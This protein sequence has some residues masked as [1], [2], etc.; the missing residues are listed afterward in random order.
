MEI[1]AT[2]ESLDAAITTLRGELADAFSRISSQADAETFRIAYLSRNGKVAA[3]FESMKTLP[4]TDKPVF[5]KKL[6]EL[7]KFAEGTF[8]ETAARIETAAASTRST[9]DLTLPGR[10]LPQGTVHPITQTLNEIKSIFFAMGFDLADGPEIEDDYHNFE[11]LNFH[12]NHP[13]RDMQDTFFVAKDVLLRTHTSP[14]QIRVMK[15]Q[16]PPIRTIMPGR[17][18]RNE[19]IS[20]RSY[21]MFHQ[22]EG[23]FVDK[24]VTFSELKGTLVAF[25]KQF[26]GS[27]IKYKFRPSYFPFTEPSLEM[28]I[29]CF[30]C[31]GKGC[32]IC[33]HS[34]WLEVLG[35]GM[36]H[37]NVFK[38]VG[39]DSDAYTGYAF[40]MGIERITLLRHGV[41]DIRLLFENDVRFLRQF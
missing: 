23:L 28:D 38:N 36:V 11:A 30:L 33:K 7:K 25:A 24:H 27:D 31:K 32:R 19:A 37:P 2:A 13:A 8:A 41:T 18:Y 5:G 22:V 29:T 39:Y 1:H 40:G 4:G 21:C 12:P 10:T 35:A 14:V 17:V 26:Y 9:I 6:N 16:Q 15:N 20:A 34:G 3:L